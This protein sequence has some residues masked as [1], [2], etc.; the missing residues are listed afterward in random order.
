LL[1]RRKKTDGRKAGGGNIGVVKW[2]EIKWV[3]S[4]PEKEMAKK[5]ALQWE[6]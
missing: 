5:K 6:K 4:Y 2:V 3:W 1:K